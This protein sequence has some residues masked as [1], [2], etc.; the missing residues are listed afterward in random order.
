MAVAWSENSGAN[1]ESP[2]R[3]EATE[4]ADEENA[5]GVDRESEDEQSEDG[6]DASEKDDYFST[7]PS[8]TNER[9]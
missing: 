3:Q 7:H 2:R 9:E 1:G 6:E 5:R 4:P 8:A